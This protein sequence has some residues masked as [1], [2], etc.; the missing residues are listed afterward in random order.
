[1]INFSKT[2]ILIRG[3]PNSGK[4]S[5]ADYI[6]YLYNLCDLNTQPHEKCEICCADNHFE[7]DGKYLFNP[8]ELHI[9][10]KKCQDKFVKALQNNVELIIISN[11]S[12]SE[13]ELNFYVD[14]IKEYGYGL[15]S[16]VME[17]RFEGGDNGHNVP[18][19]SLSK[20]ENNI[21][22]SLKLR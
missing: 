13:R 20:M 12:S 3:C 21:K 7:K 10:H 22:N 15:F 4:S 9:A 11:T 16:I 19:S 5:F 1:M 14:K 17:K 8:A 2:V 6:S 18:E